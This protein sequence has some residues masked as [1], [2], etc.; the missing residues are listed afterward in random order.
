MRV[1]PS[2]LRPHALV[3][4]LQAQGYDVSALVQGIFEGHFIEGRNIG[5]ASDLEAI[6]LAAGL[7]ARPVRAALDHTPQR[8]ALD[9]LARAVGADSVPIFVFD[10]RLAVT[11]AQSTSVLAEAI[12]GRHGGN[13]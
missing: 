8:L 12:A 5:L 6:A 13:G 11:G 3:D 7:P 4:R 2:T 10:H 9:R 1:R